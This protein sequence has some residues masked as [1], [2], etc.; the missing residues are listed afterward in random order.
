[1]G[2]KNRQGPHIHP[3]S[4]TS[5]GGDAENKHLNEKC[6]TLGLNAESKIQ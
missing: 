3:L 4:L 6:F 1:M 2:G 5:S